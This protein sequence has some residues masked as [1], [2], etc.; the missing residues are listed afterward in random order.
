MNIE[1]FCLE[2]DVTLFPK[3]RKILK[4]FYNGDYREL[5]AV[6]GRRSGKDF[7]S[8]VLAL[9]ETRCLLEHH[10][11]C[12]YYNLPANP[13]YILLVATSSDQSRILLPEVKYRIS[14]LSFFKNRIGKVDDKGIHILTNADI[15]R[16]NNSSDKTC[17]SVIIKCGHCNSEDLLG[18]R[19]YCLL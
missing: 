13:I 8:V 14:Q 1:K 16:N 3:Q 18:K 11:P 6:L 12:E 10:D 4:D 2:F 5:V 19:I 7:L 9:Y 17:G 15:K